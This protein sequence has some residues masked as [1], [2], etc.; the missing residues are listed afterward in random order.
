MAVSPVKAKQAEEPHDLYI[1]SDEHGRVIYV[2]LSWN[3]ISRVYSHRSNSPWGRA[4]ARIELRSFP[5]R[6]EAEQF[7]RALIQH[8][9]PAF[10]K[11]NHGGGLSLA[12]STAAAINAIMDS[13]VLWRRATYGPDPQQPAWPDRPPTFE[14]LKL[15][16]E[17]ADMDARNAFASSR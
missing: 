17:R 2:G 13:Y 15:I 6:H 10:N 14:D 7:E 3:A 1:V 11:A 4:W 12:A 16:S 5:T 8:H 9:R